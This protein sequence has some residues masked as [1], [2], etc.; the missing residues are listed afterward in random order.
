MMEAERV[1]ARCTELNVHLVE[2]GLPDLEDEVIRELVGGLA[3][4]AATGR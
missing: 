4:R 3:H 1:H 2:K